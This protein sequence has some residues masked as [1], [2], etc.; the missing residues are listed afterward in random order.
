MVKYDVSL[1]DKN[2][3]M[4]VITVEGSSR[5]D[6]CVKAEAEAKKEHKNKDFMVVHSELTDKVDVIDYDKIKTEEN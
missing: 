3:E 2:Q 1:E 4:I 5:R 6:A